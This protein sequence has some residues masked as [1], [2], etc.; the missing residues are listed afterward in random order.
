MKRFFTVPARYVTI[1]LLFGTAGLGVDGCKDTA[2]IDPGP[3][4]AGLSVSGASLQPPFS[5]ETTVYSADLPGNTPD[6]TISATKSDPNDVLS[7]AVTAPAGQATGQTTIPS[8]GPGS[9][10]DVSLTV[11]SSDGKAKIYTITL[12]GISL[13]GDNSLK[14]LTVSPGTLTPAFSAG[15]QVYTVNV[16]TAVADITVSATKSD[17]NAVISGDV[18]NEGR[19]TLKLDGPGTTKI[20]SMIVTAPNGTSKTYTI[21]VKRAAPSSD[22][23]VSD[24]TVSPGSLD[25]DFASGI[26]N[27]TVD[28]ANDVDSVIISATK[29]DSNAEMSA[30]GT[31][32]AAAGTQ[33]GQVSVPLRG[34]RTGVDITVTAQDR[35]STKTYTITVTRSRR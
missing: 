9:T 17:P 29:S 4:L 10:K 2:S 31:V 3:Q 20:V 8:P 27:Y 15:T 14:S 16:A 34:R 30:L 13:G 24:L 32:I 18:P 19:A 26:L 12:R 25:P 23:D 21:T 35:M 11:T 22:D 6:V 1:T 5:S 33:T 28:V 7:G